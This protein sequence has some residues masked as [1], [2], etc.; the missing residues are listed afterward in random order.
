MK[1][2]TLVAAAVTAAVLLVPIGA[3]G[4]SGRST[5]SAAALTPIA[6]ENLKSGDASWQVPGFVPTVPDEQTVAAA[7]RDDQVTAAA[8]TNRP[9][10]A[11]GDQTGSRLEGYASVTSVN[12]GG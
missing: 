10:S 4:G 8:V 9:C 7:A 6:Q 5:A 2:T 1:R 12:R 3:S 11:S